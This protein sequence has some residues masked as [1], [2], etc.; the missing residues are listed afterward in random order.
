MLQKPKGYYG[1]KNKVRCAVHKKT[2][3]AIANEWMSYHH[4]DKSP[5][6]RITSMQTDTTLS[7]L[8][9]ICISRLIISVQLCLHNY[10]V[11][12]NDYFLN[13]LINVQSFPY[14]PKV[15]KNIWSILH[16]I[17]VNIDGAIYRNT[18]C[19]STLTFIKTR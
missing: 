16:S 3:V 2:R 4:N 10:F 14:A 5:Q 19:I 6:R 17:G 9:C 12:A 18:R 13:I 8:H 15:C 7:R 1:V 11:A